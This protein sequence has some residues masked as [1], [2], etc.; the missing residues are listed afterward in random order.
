MM[1]IPAA[2]ASRVL[3]NRT[4]RPRRRSCPSKPVSTPASTFISVLLPAPFSPTMACN[5]PESVSKYA[6]SSATSPGN[7]I[8]TRSISISGAMRSLDTV[9]ASLQSSQQENKHERDQRRCRPHARRAKG[10]TPF[11]VLNDK[12]S[13]DTRHEC[14]V[15]DRHNPQRSG[16]EL[17]AAP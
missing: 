5:S 15:H 6:L 14:H 3:R 17:H 4:G 9:T 2:S 16:K 13:H 10:S 1:L 7:R 8:V 12:G 11:R